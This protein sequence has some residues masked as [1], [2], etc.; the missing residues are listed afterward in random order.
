MKH[1][2]VILDLGEMY[3]SEFVGSIENSHVGLKFPLK[4]IWDDKMQC[5][6]LSEQPPY[7]MMWGKYWYRSGINPTMVLDL[8]DVV[9][10]VDDLVEPPKERGKI[11]V[12]IA[13]NDGTLLK[14]VN[15]NYMKVGIDPCKGEIE[16][17]GKA[18]ANMVVQD[19]FS[20]RAYESLELWDKASVITCCGMFS[21]TKT[22]L[23]FLDGVFDI[24]ADDGILVI[25]YPYTPTMLANGDV[26]SI[27]HENYAYHY[28]EN[29]FDMMIVSGLRPFLVNFNDM[30]GGSIRIY[31]DKHSRPVHKNVLEALQRERKIDKKD[32][33][34]MFS[35]IIQVHKF[36]ITD[37]TKTKTMEGMEFWGYGA[38]TLGNTLLQWY[39]LDGDDVF[40]IADANPSKEGRYT[41]G[42]G[43][44]ITSEKEWRERHPDFTL[45][46]PFQ[47]QEYFQSKEKAYLDKGGVFILPCPMPM[48]ISKGGIN[49]L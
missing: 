1:N 16:D 30:D 47:F 11:W 48:L 32:S 44:K 42:S 45:I 49:Y 8:R 40:R 38:S 35:Q 5:P 25:Q 21:K 7:D 13:S 28:F 2:E 41:K 31:A 46:L 12:D 18:N 29:V 43:I 17:L 14:E 6:V 9:K 19:Y 36:K 3:V 39:G 34:N 23:E 22:P 4:L 27:C 33:W 20:K 26:M 10:S 15:K 37:F 24:L